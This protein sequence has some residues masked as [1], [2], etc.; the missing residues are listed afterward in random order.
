LAFPAK[1]TGAWLKTIGFTSSNDSS[2]I[3][4]LKFIG[5]IDQGGIP[6]AVWTAF[7]GSKHKAILGEAIRKGYAELYAVYPDAHRRSNTDLSHVFNTSSSAGAQVITKTVQTF[8]ALVEDAEF[9]DLSPPTETTMH[10]GP[11]HTPLAT[12]SP[13]IPAPKQ[14]HDGPALHID[15]QIHISPE[16]TSEQ[17]EKI[18]ESMAKH[19]YGR[20]DE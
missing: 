4:V 5:F 10:S 20:K 19:L 16:S 8:K 12:G 7:R 15:I 9:S 11:L 1:V 14:M 13:Q 2:L 3:G 17:I 18:F 6:T